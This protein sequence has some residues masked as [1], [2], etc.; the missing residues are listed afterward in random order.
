[1]FRLLIEAAPWAMKLGITPVEI[2][3]S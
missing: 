3:P 2:V 1:L